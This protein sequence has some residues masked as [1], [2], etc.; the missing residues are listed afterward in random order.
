MQHTPLVSIVIPA[1]NAEATIVET[2]E[3]ACQQTYSNLEI[4]V[5]NDGSQ[6]GT[7]DKVK[8]FAE[9]DNRIRL[10]NQSN[11][12]VA[13][14]R[15]N[16]I[17]QAKADFIA[18]LDADDL[19]HATKIEKQ[20][21]LMLSGG[22]ELGLVYCPHRRIDQHGLVTS[23]AVVSRVEGWVFYRHL[24]KN[25]VGSGSTPLVRRTALLEIGGYSSRLRDNR[26]G[27]CEDYLMQLQVARNYKFAC[28]PEYLLGYRELPNAMSSDLPRM[29]QS[30]LLT[31]AIMAENSEKNVSD[32][33]KACKAAFLVQ[34]ARD[35]IRNGRLLNGARVLSQALAEDPKST[36]YHSAWH[37]GMIPLFLAKLAQTDRSASA[38]PLHP[39][40]F[41]DFSP[42]EGLRTQSLR[43]ARPRLTKLE[44][45]DKAYGRAHP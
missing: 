21:R 35:R 29:I 8:H 24:D 12:G 40:H 20:L 43:S 3:S 33:I 39:R 45:L 6:D 32:F 13:Y 2:L 31:Y 17:L 16:G 9:R 44:A 34:T 11:A 4:L 38:T 23:T 10:I 27:G 5:V 19:W 22:E 25:F 18:P 15:N 41:Y 28:V 1:Y 7:V 26:A 37:V 36:F 14:A 42:T 30:R